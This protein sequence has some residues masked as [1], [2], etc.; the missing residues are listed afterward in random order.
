M[1]P[2]GWIQFEV[3]DIV[4]NAKRND[5]ELFLLVKEIDHFFGHQLVTGCACWRNFRALA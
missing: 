3:Q 5:S 2:L 1:R 4:E